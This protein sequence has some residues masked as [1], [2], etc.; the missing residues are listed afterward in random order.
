MS[1][2]VII[3]DVAADASMWDPEEVAEDI[4]A[5][6]DKLPTFGRGV[7]WFLQDPGGTDVQEGTFISAEWSDPDPGQ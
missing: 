7:P 1:R 2:L 4:L 3:I 5:H 6:A